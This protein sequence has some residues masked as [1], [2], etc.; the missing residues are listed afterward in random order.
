MFS[1]LDPAVLQKYHVVVSTYDTVK[2]EYVA[3]SSSAKDES[4]K[5]KASSKAKVVDSDNNDDDDSE[6]DSFK[7]AKKA[8]PKAKAGAKKCA[9]FE[10]KW[11]RGVLGAFFFSNRTI[12]SF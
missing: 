8:K 2:S 5:S 3:Y 4:K 6:S 1:Y 12:L 7:K 9:L 11:F 10:V